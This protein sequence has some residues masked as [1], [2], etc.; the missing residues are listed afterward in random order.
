M[1]PAWKK[2]CE[3]ALQ[4]YET[5][6]LNNREMWKEVKEHFTDSICIYILYLLVYT[7]N[8]LLKYIM[9][10]EWVSFQIF[11]I[12]SMSGMECVFSQAGLQITRISFTYIAQRS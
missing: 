6:S 1:Q 12:V 11:V 3:Q 9:E 8:N 7:I 10:V 4:K 5:C 2:V